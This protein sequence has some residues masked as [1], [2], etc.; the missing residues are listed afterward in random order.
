MISKVLFVDDEP[1]ILIAYQRQAGKQYKI[2]T[3]EDGVQGL[4][5]LQKQGPFAVVVSDY[6]M[7]RVDGVQLLAAAKDISP[8]TVRIMLT[9]YAESEVAINAVNEGHIFRFLT[10]PCSTRNLL[11]ALEAGVEQYRLVTA[12]RDLLEKTLSGSV[13]VLTEIIGL[14]SP[15]A[16]G[17]ASRIKPYVS[18]IATWLEL[19][20]VWEFEVAAMLSQIGCVTLP[21]EV[22]EKVQIEQSLKPEEEQ[23]YSQCPEIGRNLI[24]HIPRLENSADM[25]RAQNQHTYR[26]TEGIEFK[27]EDRIA[28]GG[29]ILEVALD[30]DQ[31]LTRDISEKVALKRMQSGPYLPEA[32]EALANLANRL[33]K[34]VVRSFRVN[35]LNTGMILY[36]DVFSK[37]EVLLASRGDEVTQSVI[38]R[39]RN[40]H[41]SI[42]V[43]EPIRAAEITGVSTSRKS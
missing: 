26:H 23:M 21:P 24:R 16:F 19:P 18:Q 38:G 41:N 15:L 20:D 25:I 10:K 39:L 35:E 27:E 40:F 11:Q 36:Q 8:D 14:L 43:V 34:R 5:V 3:A 9:V 4:K 29:H 2:V 12:E 22:L 32:L 6:R 31:M 42:G 30:F 28:L 13:K 37:D 1:D 33:D 7:P 17:R